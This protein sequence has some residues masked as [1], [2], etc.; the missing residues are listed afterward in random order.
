MLPQYPRLARS[1]L[2]AA[3][4]GLAALLHGPA[5]AAQVPDQPPAPGATCDGNKGE[6]RLQLRIQGVRKA[7]GL[8]TV[9]LY[10]DDADK[11]LARKGRLARVRVPATAPET[12]V[13]IPAPTAGGYAVAVY[14]D[15]NGDHDFNRTFLGMPAEGY[16]FSNNAETTLGLPHFEDVRFQAGMGDTAVVIQLRY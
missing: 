11:F 2:L 9:T 8:M 12:V 6:V 16:G 15:Q 3:T 7:E 13:C 10:P 14:H 5:A 4:L 1:G